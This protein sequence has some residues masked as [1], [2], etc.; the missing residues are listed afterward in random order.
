MKKLLALLLVL[1]LLPVYTLAEMNEDG[2]IV[3]TLPGAEFFFTPMEGYCL[4]RESSASV[5]NRLGLSQREMLPYMEQMGVYAIMYDA[6]FTCELN[7]AAYETVETDFD[8]LTEYGAEMLLADFE[9]SYRDQAYDVTSVEL[10][11][12][13]EGHK[14]IRSIASFGNG[15]GQPMHMAEYMTNQA[16]YTVQIVLFALNGPVT[17]AHMTLAESVADSLWVIE[18]E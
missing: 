2:D 9:Y 11:Q 16:G 13:P 7:V 8:E 5:F 17:D 10:Y 1:C 6:E 12:A 4:T 3:V 18:T 14:F 15:D